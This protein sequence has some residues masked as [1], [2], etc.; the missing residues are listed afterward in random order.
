MNSYMEIL[1]KESD[2]NVLVA[3]VLD[4]LNATLTPSDEE[5]PAPGAVVSVGGGGG[6]DD[7]ADEIGDRLTEVIIQKPPF[8]EAMVKFFGCYDFAVRK[9]AVQLL[10]SLL[11][12]RAPEVQQ[13]LIQSSTGVSRIVDLLHDKREVI[14]NNVVLM[15]S[16]LS[17]G[18]SSLQQLLAYENAFQLLFEIIYQEPL[19]SESRPSRAMRPLASSVRSSLGQ[20]IF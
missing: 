19:D 6:G 11:R 17:R 10:I 3:L 1:E 9:N 14:R 4:V 20:T 13:S 16:E 18:N 8:M 15:L 7:E 5:E 12:H 2:V